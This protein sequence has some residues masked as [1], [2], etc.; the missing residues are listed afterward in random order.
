M[1]LKDWAKFIWS[2]V[3][4][5]DTDDVRGM[6]CG[7]LVVHDGH[8]Y[9]D[10]YSF[11]DGSGDICI[12]P[13]SHD[14]LEEVNYLNKKNAFEESDHAE[15]VRLVTKYTHGWPNQADVLDKIKEN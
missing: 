12:E 5:L 9:L 8:T 4:N 11:N 14:L 7:C 3:L 6:A 2:E 1:E 13:S 15:L 10:V